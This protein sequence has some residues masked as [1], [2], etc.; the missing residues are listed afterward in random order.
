MIVL[1]APCHVKIHK[2]TK[3]IDKIPGVSNCYFLKFVYPKCAKAHLWLCNLKNFP[4][5]TPP[6]PLGERGRPPPAPSPCSACGLARGRFAPPAPQSQMPTF[7]RTPKFSDRSPPLLKLPIVGTT[8]HFCNNTTKSNVTKQE[9]PH[10][11][12]SFSSYKG[13]VSST[14]LGSCYTQYFGIGR[15]S[16]EIGLA[17]AGAKLFTTQSFYSYRHSNIIGFQQYRP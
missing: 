16:E 14:R 17:S 15:F 1:L 9:I 2:T 8:R 13:R 4:K 10:E 12:V 5:V 6:D 3:L 11:F 7:P